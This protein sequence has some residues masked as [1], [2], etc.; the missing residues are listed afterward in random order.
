VSATLI[1]TRRPI[2]GRL[3]AHLRCPYLRW[4]I[5]HA[6]ADKRHHEALYR[7]AM[8]RLPEQIALDQQHIT[9]LTKQLQRA[10]ND[11]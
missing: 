11:T 8:R 3:L 4:L 7:D 5:R 10:L 9:A 6:E 1:P 2:L